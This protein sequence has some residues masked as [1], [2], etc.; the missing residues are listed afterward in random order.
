M[1]CPNCGAEINTDLKNCIYCNKSLDE[2]R[3][4]VTYDYE[5]LLDDIFPNLSEC[6]GFK[7]NF[8][9][10]DMNY[11]FQMERIKTVNLV[12]ETIEK[13]DCEEF[14]KYAEYSQLEAFES[15]VIKK[16]DEILKAARKA[17]GAFVRK[18]V[19]KA[20]AKNYFNT[21]VDYSSSEIAVY[22]KQ[23]VNEVKNAVAQAEEFRKMQ[24]EEQKQM[25]SGG[26]WIGGGLGIGGAIKGALNAA[27]LNAGTNIARGAGNAINNLYQSGIDKKNIN[28]MRNEVRD[29]LCPEVIKAFNKCYR[30]LTD[31]A[32]KA[33][34]PE[35]N[36]DAP[37]NS[38]RIDK[39][40]EKIAKNR[41]I[42]VEECIDEVCGILE[43][44]PYE[45]S[46]YP[47]MYAI[48]NGRMGKELTKLASYFFDESILYECFLEIDLEIMKNNKVSTDDEDEELKRKWRVLK[49]IEENNPV[50][51]SELFFEDKR[52]IQF[53]DNLLRLWIRIFG[54]KVIEEQYKYED[55][56]DLDNVWNIAEDS[57]PVSLY[58]YA[59]Y[60]LMYK[61]EISSGNLDAFIK[62]SI[63]LQE[64]I[65]KQDKL[66]VYIW[67]RIMF[68][69]IEEQ[70]GDVSEYMK[71]IEMLSDKDFGLAQGFLGEIYLFG[72][73][74]IEI[75]KAKCEILMR[76][77]VWNHNPVAIGYV[78]KF[79]ANGECGYKKDITM[80]DEFLNIAQE[81][82]L[83]FA[84]KE[85]EKLRR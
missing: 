72:A 69:I 63:D 32:R 85:R 45:Y 66:A 55:I 44:Y 71:V 20:T 33:L 52:V 65:K 59:A 13:K 58:V 76:K 25:H 50:Y 68:E 19:D 40:S 1:Y 37:L 18:N 4:F 79:Y 6:K 64:L 77:A 14:A 38:Y 12:I 47:I 30:K 11:N 78:G 16:G 41:D 31:A 60:S 22:S 54:Q 27:I 49:R 81:Y 26:R 57:Q 5:R 2:V 10:R 74:G 84:K 51:E 9:G 43:Q 34:L 24:R 48:E 15:G 83:D 46:I 75:N 73:D 3:K 29:L 17:F 67:T 80:A 23:L 7:L 8:M 35:I 70:G 21:Q 82:R 36:F 62:K 39:F 56:Q 42:T 53:K 61:D 28:K